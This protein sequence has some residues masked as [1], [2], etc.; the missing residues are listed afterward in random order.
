MME[1]FFN[2]KRRLLVNTSSQR[3][4]NLKDKKYMKKLN[5]YICL[6]KFQTSCSK[7]H[8]SVLLCIKDYCLTTVS[9]EIIYCKEA[10]TNLKQRMCYTMAFSLRGKHYVRP[11]AMSVIG[12]QLAF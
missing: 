12:S 5:L 10:K 9:V 4:A 6:S 11:K 1:N 7:N 8:S 3:Y 2:L